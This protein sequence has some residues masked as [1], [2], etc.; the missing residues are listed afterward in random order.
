M[1]ARPALFDVY[2]DYLRPRGGRAPVSALVKLLAPLGIAAPAVR[3]AVSR[4]VRQGLLRPLRLPSGPGYSL[5]PL[6]LRRL[7]ET[8]ARIT[9]N[10]RSGWD[11]RFD[12]IL[13]YAPV[14]RAE[15]TRLTA[16]GYGRLADHA[17]VAPRPADEAPAVLDAA[18][19][20][21]ERFSATH[22]AG[23]TGA[24]DV[25]SRAWDL[26]GIGR[27]YAEL[28]EEQ[29]PI[30]GAITVRSPD[31]EAYA[32]RV[33]LIHRWRGLL[34]RD[35][36]LPPALLPPRWPGTGAAGF[37]DRHAARLRPAAERHVERCLGGVTRSVRVGFSES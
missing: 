24:A 14:G 4:M 12:L 15:A 35:P 3:T 36:Q 21:Y 28:V 20:R 16:L 33:G 7:D 1:R 25:V 10:G 34:T 26:P 8:A 27:A 6:G 29:R 32:V 18:A 11:G 31:E 23:T 17:W 37:V 30:V 2:G 13:P 5:T 22:P 19:V 9:R